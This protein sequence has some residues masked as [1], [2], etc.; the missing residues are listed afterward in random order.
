MH[1]PKH[2][3]PFL[4][5][6]FF[7]LAWKRVREANDKTDSQT[8]SKTIAENYRPSNYNPNLQRIIKV[9]MGGEKK[10]GRKEK[11]QLKKIRKFQTEDD[12]QP[13]IAFLDISQG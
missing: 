7:F 3:F 1:Q 9:K 5:L 6:F 2:I 8:S 11:E 12:H 10:K 13:N 4:F